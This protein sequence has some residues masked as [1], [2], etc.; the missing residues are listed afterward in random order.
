M[1]RHEIAEMIAVTLENTLGVEP[2]E[3]E[4]DG[5]NVNLVGYSMTKDGN[6]ELKIG[7]WSYEGTGDGPNE[8]V[9]AT[10]SVKVKP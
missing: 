7:I 2:W 4:D 3:V 8:I 9:T 10:V 6:L 5:Y 1:D